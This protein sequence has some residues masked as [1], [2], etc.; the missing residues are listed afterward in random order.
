MFVFK[1]RRDAGKQL[2][3]KLLAY[4]KYHPI[5]LALPRGGI[6]IGHEIAK[7]LNVNLEVLV[8]R[9]LGSPFNPEFAIGAI[10]ED[11]IIFLDETT[12]QVLGIPNQIIKQLVNTETEELNRRVKI[13]RGNKKMILLKNKVAIIVD[14]GLATGATAMAAIKYASKQCPKEIIFAAPVCT[15]DSLEKLKPFVSKT[16][17]I[18]TPKELTSISTYYESFPQTSDEDVIKLLHSNARLL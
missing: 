2:A 7:Q 17:S 14:D 16:I 6:V 1:D 12:I 8:V 18:L 3:K 4:K 11:E 9:K 10:T 13:Y 15:Y 5:I